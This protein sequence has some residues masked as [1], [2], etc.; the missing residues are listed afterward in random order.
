M[1]VVNLVHQQKRYSRDAAEEGDAI[2]THVSNPSLG[3]LED[4]IKERKRPYSQTS[5]YS[6]A[7][8]KVQYIL[9]SVV[10]VPM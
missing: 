5:L 8:D 7:R 1:R 9:V 4:R 10:W 2:P 6:I 3:S